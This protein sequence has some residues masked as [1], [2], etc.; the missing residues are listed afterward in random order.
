MP[1]GVAVKRDFI[2]TTDS[3]KSTEVD[4]PSP[5][6]NGNDYIKQGEKDIKRK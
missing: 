5:I 1:K 3:L 6:D 2:P 4:V